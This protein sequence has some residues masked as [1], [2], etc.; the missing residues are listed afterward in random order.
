MALGCFLAALLGTALTRARG[1]ALRT[2]AFLEAFFTGRSFLS[3]RGMSSSCRFA[4]ALLLFGRWVLVLNRRESTRFPMP[5]ATYLLPGPRNGTAAPSRKLRIIASF[6]C[7]EPHPD[8]GGTCL[9][10]CLTAE[11]IRATPS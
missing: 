3:S 5:P 7:P 6:E 11:N 8:P 2:A 4:M 9:A 10:I 1:E